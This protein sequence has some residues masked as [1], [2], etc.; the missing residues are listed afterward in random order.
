MKKFWVLSGVVAGVLSAVPGMAKQYTLASPDGDLQVQINTDDGLSYSV[1]RGGQPILPSVEAS[2]VLEN[3]NL[4]ASGAQPVKDSQ[5]SEESTISLPVAIKNSAIPDHF[6]ELALEYEDGSRI[7]FRAYDDAVAHRFETK[8][9]GD[10]TVRD[11]RFDVSFPAGAKAWFAKPKDWFHSYENA[12]VT[13]PIGALGEAKAQLPLLVDIGA[14][15]KV[16]ITESDLVDYPG[17]YFT[18]AGTDSLKSIFPPAVKSEIKNDPAKDNW[19][20]SFKPDERFD[21][22]AQTSGTRTFPW[23]IIAVAEKDI[24]LLNNEI[25]YKLASPSKIGDASWIKPG[26][27]AWDWWNNWNLTG[28]DF[29]A[30]PNTETYKYFIDFASKNGIPYIM[31]DEGWYE[32]GDIM[33]PTDVINVPEIVNYGKSKNVDVILWT[34]WRTLDDKMEEAMSTFQKWGVKGIKVDFMDRDDQD[35]VNFYFRCADMAA[36]HKLMVDYHGCHKPAGLQRTYPNVVNFEGVPGLEYCKWSDSM[37]SP[38]LVATIPY[39]R[40]F[41]GPMDYTPGALR[42]GAPFQDWE[43][44]P[45]MERVRSRLKAADDGD[46]Q[47]VAILTAVLSDGLDAVEAAC[48][49]ALVE[50]VCS[51]AVILNILARRRDPAPVV[52]ILTP[53]ALRLQHEPQ[54]DCARYDSLRRA[55]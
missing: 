16:L 47:M 2:M 25:V 34:V 38:P 52:T 49:Q 8:A 43:L 24:D 5:R 7:L 33:K 31:M 55:S 53:D 10:L 30:G 1:N 15:G 6:N 12:Y 23:R 4:P 42:N 50:N 14:P 44:P 28:V 20:R 48:R 32:L 40:M 41:A 22:I 54:A 19:D 26:L 46:R 21:Y 17:L 37:S 39:T 36:R 27:V 13:E 51:S 29:V 18:G 9:T 3:G 35:I 11:E 45:A